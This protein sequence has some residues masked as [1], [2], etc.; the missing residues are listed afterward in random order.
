MRGTLSGGGGI[1]CYCTLH[2]AVLAAMLPRNPLV[3]HC[4]KDA[5]DIHAEGGREVRKEANWRRAKTHAPPAC[6]WCGTSRPPNQ[7]RP[8][9]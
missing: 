2:A 1:R 4:V 8:N 5:N 6:S 7:L 9:G 3:T